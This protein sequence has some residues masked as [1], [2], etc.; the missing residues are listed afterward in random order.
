M[1]IIKLSIAASILLTGQVFA[2]SSYPGLNYPQP[3]VNDNKVQQ[4]VSMDDLLSAKIAS[5]ENAKKSAVSELRKQAIIEIAT[6]LGTSSGLAY[7]IRERRIEL[8]KISGQMDATFDFT[9]LTIDNGVM[10]PVLTEGLSNYA[11]ESDDQV[12]IADKIYKIEAQ[13]KFVSVYPDWRSYL[14][15]TF[16][17]YDTPSSAYLPKDD[18]EKL[19][20]DESV[21]KGWT[22]GLRQADSIIES[23]FNRLVRD[24]MGMIKYKILLAEG[25]ITPT[26][27]AG[28]NLG[29]TG[30][31][32]EMAIND[33]I[34]R[35]SDHSALNP[36]VKDWK[37]PY[38]VTNNQDGILK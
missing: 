21:K 29:V 20:W 6:A 16:P 17:T 5:T 12:R 26:I 15:F 34:F 24:Y 13:A 37:V 27:I 33:Q 8:D 38:P 7:R 9:K 14:S 22:Q 3:S 32:R 1:K 10:A 23:S 11:Q 35:I 36:T 18:G 31:G 25:L 4:L 2:Q 30:G 28:Q 19:I